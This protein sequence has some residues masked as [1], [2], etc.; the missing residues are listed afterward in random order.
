MTDRVRP[1]S[2][3]EAFGMASGAAVVCGALSVLFS[4][5]TAAAATLTALGLASWVSLSRRRGS[6]SRCGLGRASVLALAILGASAAVFIDPPSPIAP[7]RGLLLAA[8]LL[9]LVVAERARS[10]RRIPVFSHA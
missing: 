5:L 2:D 6:L 7:T 3:S 10:S 9:P 4:P 1:L 8:G